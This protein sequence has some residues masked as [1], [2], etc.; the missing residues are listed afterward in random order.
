[1][2]TQVF[3]KQINQRF[4]GFLPIVVDLETSGCVAATDAILEIAAVTLR[5]DEQ[6]HLQLDTTFACNVEPFEGAR[7]DPRSLE[8]TNINLKQPFRFALT[9]ELALKQLFEFVR[10]VVRQHQC[11]KAILVGHN[12]HFDLNFI[13]TA[14]ARWHLRKRNP[15]H[16]FSCFDTATL[17]GLN[18]GITV[19][20]RAAKAAGISFDHNQAHS[21]VYDA[22]ITAKLFCKIVNQF[23]AS[24]H[25]ELLS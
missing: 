18:Y 25:K 10:Q 9:E 19:L 4:D 14:S 2:T 3:T 23:D 21:A 20:A 15:F 16:S 8:V 1:M 6:G 17:S 22:Q 12:A 13:C 7:I 11:R 5:F 24:K